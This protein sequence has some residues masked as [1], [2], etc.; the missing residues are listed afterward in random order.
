M[1]TVDLDSYTLSTG[2]HNTP[3][4]GV[5]LLELAASVLLFGQMVEVTS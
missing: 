5:C 3:D 1:T 2:S 4:Q